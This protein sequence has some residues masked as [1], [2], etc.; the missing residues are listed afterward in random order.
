MLLGLERN[1]STLYLIDYGLS[2]LYRDSTTG[3]HMQFSGHK[4]LVGTARY[5]SLNTHMGFEQ[6]RR[7]DLESVGYVLIYLIKEKLPWQIQKA[8]SKAFLHELIMREKLK[9]TLR[10]LTYGLCSTLIYTAHR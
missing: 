9:T 10:D 4:S 3:A 1:T 2:S 6:S 5:V 8:K 7:D